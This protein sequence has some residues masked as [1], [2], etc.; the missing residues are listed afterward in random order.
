MLTG[1][2]TFLVFFFFT[3]NFSINSFF[4]WLQVLF[5]EIAPFIMI[6]NMLLFGYRSWTVYINRQKFHSV[7][8]YLRYLQIGWLLKQRVRKWLIPMCFVIAHTEVQ[9]LV[10]HQYTYLLLSSNTSL[11]D[12]WAFSTLKS[13]RSYRNHS[14]FFI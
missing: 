11:L 14:L 6:F 7:R 4:L 1:Y 9:V 2:F 8:L 5:F 13:K 10:I 3:G 12:F